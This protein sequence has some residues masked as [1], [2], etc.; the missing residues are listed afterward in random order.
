MN[1]LNGLADNTKL[2]YY[3]LLHALILLY[4]IYALCCKLAAQHEFLSIGFIGLYG[5]AMFIMLIYAFFW[6]KVL[7]KFP[8]N[9]AFSN[10]AVTIFW[11]MLLGG[12]FFLESINL[13][14]IIGAILVIMGIILVVQDEK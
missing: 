1:K 3:I 7:K 9:V 6:Q 4:A 10:K 8:L 14:K 13:A 11:G 2:K 5:C 12:V